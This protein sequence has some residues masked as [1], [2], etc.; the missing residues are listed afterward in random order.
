MVTLPALHR[1]YPA[2]GWSDGGMDEQVR[3]WRREFAARLKAARLA[4]GL[5]QKRLAEMVG[6][7]QPTLGSWER[8]T[9]P[10]SLTD[11]LAIA[12]A[13]G[14]HPESLLPG[15]PPPV[16]VVYEGPFVCEGCRA[17][18]R[19]RKRPFRTTRRRV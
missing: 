9:R 2:Y 16:P 19:R 6:V 11:F 12:D 3:K 17:R 8:A 4:A 18:Q 7:S 13:L 15:T 10:C 5:T 14:V 1:D